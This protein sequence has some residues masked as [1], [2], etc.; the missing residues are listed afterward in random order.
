[1]TARP[2]PPDRRGDTP[3]A[4]LLGAPPKGGRIWGLRLL[5]LV[6]VLPMFIALITGRGLTLLSL[7]GGTGLLVLAGALIRRGLDATAAYEQRRFAPPPPPFRLTGAAAL[8]GAFGLVASGAAGYGTLM[9]LVIAGLGFAASLVTYGVDPRAA[10][11]LPASEANRTGV[12]TEH[13]VAAVD[14]AKA[15]I[16]DIR[17]HGGRLANRELR[18]RLDRICAAGEAVVDELERDP[19]DLPRARRF[20]NVY[21]DGTR[22]V[23]RDYAK[24]EE[25]FADTELALNFKNVLATIERVFDEQLAH[26]RKDE[27]LDLEVA[28]D[29]LNTQLTKE[30]VG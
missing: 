7:L 15:K 8:A 2:E 12:R 25:D 26:L 24:R 17:R 5:P 19:K 27:A 23:V 16:A 9:T 20:L 3:V 14:E 11:R 21:L 13:I 10:K 4:G 18:T 29:V 30:G 22:D 6:F 1:M 28:I